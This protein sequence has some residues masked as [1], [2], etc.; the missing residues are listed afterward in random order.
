MEVAHRGVSRKDRV[1]GLRGRVFGWWAGRVSTASVCFE[2]GGDRL[3]AGLA[4]ASDLSAPSSPKGETPFP[5]I[6]GSRNKENGTE[7]KKFRLQP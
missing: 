3:V 7:Q 5:E 1:L 2:P 6:S 4:I